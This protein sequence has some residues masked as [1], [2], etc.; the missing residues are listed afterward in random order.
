MKIKCFKFP[1]EVCSQV[2]TI[3]IFFKQ[4]GE[5]SYGRARHYL[6]LNDSKKPMFEYHPQSKEYLT[7]KL[8]YILATIDQKQNSID[9]N[10]DQKL[11]D[12][13]FKLLMA[14]PMGF[15]PMTFSL[16]G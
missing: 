2:S 5:V 1:C 9:Q 16:E 13:S 12:S 6:K 14:G 15:E 4:N 10:A 7:E 3:Q 8:K 11:K